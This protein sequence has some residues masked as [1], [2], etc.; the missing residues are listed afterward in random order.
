MTTAR[1]PLFHFYPNNVNYFQNMC[2]NKDEIN[3]QTFISCSV[4]QTDPLNEKG[5]EMLEILL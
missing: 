3:K 2:R 1:F 4:L 5:C